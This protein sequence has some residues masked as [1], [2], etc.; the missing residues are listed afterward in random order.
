MR[1][2]SNVTQSIATKDGDDQHAPG[3]STT[4]VMCARADFRF[5]RIV[6]SVY[7][8]AYVCVAT[9]SMGRSGK[10]PCEGGQLWSDGWYKQRGKRKWMRIVRS[11]ICMFG[12]LAQASEE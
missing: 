1:L 2:G 10:V 3:R 11:A 12:K 4:F 8:H 9:A 5:P 7:E 6:R